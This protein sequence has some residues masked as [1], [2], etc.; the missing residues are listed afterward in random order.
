M[1][2][3]Q[4]LN[5]IGTRKLALPSSDTQADNSL[6]RLV[7]ELPTHT[8]SGAPR[9]AVLACHQTRRRLL[10]PVAGQ[11]RNGGPQ[12]RYAGVLLFNL[13][14]VGAG[15]TFGLSVTTSSIGNELGWEIADARS[16]RVLY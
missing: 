5:A 3:F 14:R 4:I 6:H 16:A 10:L 1:G 2:S 9:S 7:D 13:V 12:I 11:R 8:V 15:V